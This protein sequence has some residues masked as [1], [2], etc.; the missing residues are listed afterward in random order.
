MIFSV[1]N[2]FSVRRYIVTSW[3]KLS[4]VTSHFCALVPNKSMTAASVAQ[5]P[6]FTGGVGAENDGHEN[7]GPSDL[8][9]MEL[10]DMKLPDLKSSF[11]WTK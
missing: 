10:R 9:G 3:T 5:E 4:L 8:Q 11:V 2:N 1:K 7:D 6:L